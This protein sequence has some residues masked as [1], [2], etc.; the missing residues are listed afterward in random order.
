MTITTIIIVILVV[1][2][3]LRRLVLVVTTEVVGAI[4]TFI[5]IRMTL[6]TIK[7]LP[8]ENHGNCII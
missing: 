4:H 3:T 1:V 5:H 2:E 8:K 6:K 7:I